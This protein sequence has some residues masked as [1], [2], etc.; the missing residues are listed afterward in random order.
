MMMT[1][2]VTMITIITLTVVMM[3]VAIITASFALPSVRNCCYDDGKYCHII[4][5]ITSVM[6][7]TSIVAPLKLLSLHPF[8]QQHDVLNYHHSTVLIA[9]KEMRTMLMAMMMTIVIIGLATKK[10]KT[11]L[12]RKDML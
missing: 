9:A 6:F 11:I 8:H 12:K 5:F 4:L 10:S 3:V 2:I 7:R 1:T